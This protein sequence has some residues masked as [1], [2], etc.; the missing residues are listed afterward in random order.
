M[1]L[2]KE[3]SYRYLIG[4]LYTSLPVLFFKAKILFL[5]SLGIL[6]FLVLYRVKNPIVRLFF[7]YIFSASLFGL[8]V[9]GIKVFDVIV[10]ITFIYL[11]ISHNMQT[12]VNSDINWFYLFL[13]YVLFSFIILLFIGQNNGN[14]LFQEFFRFFI[15]IVTL[16]CFSQKCFSNINSKMMIWIINYIGFILLLQI[17]VMS[18]CQSHFGS[19]SNLHFGPISVNVFDYNSSSLDTMNEER[20]S[21]FFSDPNKLMC[22]F[23]LLLL[24]KKNVYNKRF[25]FYDVTF[26]IGALLT[27]ARTAF[28]VVFLYLMIIFL[29]RFFKSCEL[30]GWCFVGI[31]SII[32]ALYIYINN[33]SIGMIINSF[34]KKVLSLTGRDKTLKTDSTVQSDS[35]IMIWKIAWQYIEKKPIFGNGIFSER[36]LLP[37]PTHNTLVQLLLDYGIVGLMIYTIATMRIVIKRMNIMNWLI[38]LLIPSLVLDL[39]NYNLIYFVFAITLCKENNNRYLNNGNND[40]D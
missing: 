17:I 30:L 40:F 7:L 29:R 28:G 37:Y 27:G 13:L 15:A 23:F 1:T 36:I 38:L 18:I 6:F 34:F 8:S 32:I 9:V 21:A 31:I 16:L 19:P 11:C 4:F 3:K 39:A 14:E 12:V 35:R 26:L 5:L 20:I 24:L 25:E 2:W 10:I 22:F 33:I